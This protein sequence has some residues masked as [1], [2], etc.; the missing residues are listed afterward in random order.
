MSLLN[1]VLDSKLP[2]SDFLEKLVSVDKANFASDV[3]MYINLIFYYSPIQDPLK[4]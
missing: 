3:H 1:D 4:T 2:L